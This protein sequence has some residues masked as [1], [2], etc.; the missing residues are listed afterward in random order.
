MGGLYTKYPPVTTYASTYPPW[1]VCLNEI[2][3]FLL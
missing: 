2:N 1:L 3:I